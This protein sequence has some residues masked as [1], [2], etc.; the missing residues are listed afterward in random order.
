MKKLK[1]VR[2]SLTKELGT[3]VELGAETP[4][5]SLELAMALGW[6]NPAFTPVAVGLSFVGLTKKGLELYRKVTNK[7]PDIE[8]WVGIT[9]PLAYV[10]SFD[11]LLQQN[12][13]LREKIG[14]GVSGQEIKQ[15]FDQLGEIQLDREL[16]QQALTYF[17]E[18]LLGHALNQQLSA[19]LEQVGVDKQTIPLI[20]GWVAWRTKTCV[21]LLLEYEKS[22]SPNLVEQL[23]LYTTAALEVG[24][25]QK[26][27]SIESYLKEYIS[28]NPSDRLRLSQWQVFDETFNLPDIYVSLAAHLLD[29]N[30][31]V[32]EDAAAVNLEN[33][34]K[35]QLTNPE[36]SDRVM[37][38]QAGPGR[39]KSVFCRMFANWVREHFHPI[40]TPILIRL[41]DIHAFEDNLENTLRAAIQDDFAKSDDGWITDRNTRFLFI[42]DGFDE[43]RLEGRT[44]GELQELLKKVGIYQEQCGMS[45][46]LGHRFL[47]TGREMALQGVA[48]PRNL[49]RVEIALMDEQIQQQWF[50][51][52]GNLVEEDKVKAFQE[53]LT[54]DNC[55]QRVRELAREP[56]LLYLL[57][58]MHR[59]GKLTTEMFAGA[60]GV[61]A[62]IL[63]YQTTLDWVLTK[64]RPEELN[65]EIT[66][67][68]TEDLRRILMEAGL[69]VTQ[70][71]GE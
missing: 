69:C 63:I 5:A 56:L 7:E 49:Q 55:P 37:F 44:S 43:L 4:K 62:K 36:K 34:A 68:D 60:N 31:K 35:E 15:Q 33:W 64:Q 18:S 47:V 52:W 51:K 19:Y 71:G 48:L 2:E 13:W 16:L 53:F 17:P 59:D 11:T 10:E 6:L 24:A 67:C 42:L 38:I 39:G 3:V 25:T 57:G 20:T 21:E 28:P 66:E 41:R 22:K 12:N 32:I 26:F 29:S 14:A 40:W 58:A 45:P 54:A 23:V 30:G 27:S 61:K 8:E 9:F 1:Q 46:S 70:S 50:T 65:F